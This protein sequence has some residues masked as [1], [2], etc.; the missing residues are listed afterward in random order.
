MTGS[1]QQSHVSV[2][3]REARSLCPSIIVRVEE[4]G[5]I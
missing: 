1:S 4:R 2:H 5:E 3:V